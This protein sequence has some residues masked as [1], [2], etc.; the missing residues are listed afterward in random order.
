MKYTTASAILLYLALTDLS[1][2]RSIPTRELHERRNGLPGTTNQDVTCSTEECGQLS[3]LLHLSLP[4][5]RAD[6]V[7]IEFEPP[8]IVA[9]GEGAGGEHGIPETTGPA[10]GEGPGGNSASNEHP[11]TEHG[12]VGEATTKDPGSPPA[13]SDAGSADSAASQGSISTSD[14]DFPQAPTRSDPP[15]LAQN[16]YLVT[17]HDGPIPNTF[18]INKPGTS[19]PLDII[20]LDTD[21]DSLGINFANNGEEDKLNPGKLP[22]R[23]IGTSLW[24]S[25]SGKAMGDLKSINYQQV[26]NTEME[27]KFPQAYAALQKVFPTATRPEPVILTPSGRGST[28]VGNDAA[29]DLIT[30]S[31]FGGG[32]NKML[33]ETK[34]LE[35]REIISIELFPDADVDIQFNF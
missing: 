23:S 13:G 22:L 25:K 24:A 7:P 3:Q 1:F 10:P 33:A 15:D 34:G 35:G 12:G 18:D 29:F 28:V 19:S 17:P 32:A 31:A 2:G 11:D 9:P 8:E 5:K 26:K 6:F 21:T 20:E 16:G 4:I 30:D 14:E 27:A